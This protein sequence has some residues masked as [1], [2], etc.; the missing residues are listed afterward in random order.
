MEGVRINKHQSFPCWYIIRY[1]GG[2]SEFLW[3]D[4]QFHTGTGYTEFSATGDVPGYYSS[5]ETAEAYLLEYEARQMELEIFAA[6]REQFNS[7]R[8]DYPDIYL[9]RQLVPV[10]VLTPE[11]I[12]EKNMRTYI[13]IPD[14]KLCEE[15]IALLR[16]GGLNT[17][18]AGPLRETEGGGNPT[19]YVDDGYDKAHTGFC[20]FSWFLE[21]YDMNQESVRIISADQFLANPSQ[22]PGW[23]KPVVQ[24]LTVAKISELLG[25]EVKVVK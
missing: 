25:Y 21:N 15:V 4:L 11:K 17:C 10:T 13:Y 23:G 19:I 8:Q 3:K 22:V 18:D 24:E 14:G 1:S 9:L 5:R 16:K 7:R 20:G 2:S 12:K 6:C